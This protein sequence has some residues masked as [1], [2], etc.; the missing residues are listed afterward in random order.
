MDKKEIEFFEYYEKL[1]MGNK[2][3]VQIIAQGIYQSQ[4]NTEKEVNHEQKRP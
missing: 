4:I 1:N 3:L 2:Y